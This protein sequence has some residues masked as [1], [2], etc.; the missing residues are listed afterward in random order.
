MGRLEHDQDH[1]EHR[2]PSDLISRQLNLDPIIRAWWSVRNFQDRFEPQLQSVDSSVMQS[3]YKGDA[4]LER[5]NCQYDRQDQ[6][7]ECTD[8]FK[9]ASRK[10]ERSQVESNGN[11]SDQIYYGQGVCESTV[12]AS[13][14]KTSEGWVFGS[15]PSVN[16]HHYKAEKQS[17]GPYKDKKGQA[18]HV[19]E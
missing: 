2:F 1:Y 13:K 5:E 7:Q 18:A 10:A 15:V 17:N 11:Q 19:Q 4:V 6:G 3:R 9:G 12:Q 16:A 8:V 14:S